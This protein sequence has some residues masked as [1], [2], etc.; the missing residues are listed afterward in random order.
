MDTIQLTIDGYLD[1]EP[2]PGPRDTA[3][4]RLILSPTDDTAQETVLHCITG[5]PRIV[6]M[7]LTE[8]RS[9]D[10]LRITGL[11]TLPA[12][13]TGAVQLYVDELEVL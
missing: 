9:G 10:L 5:D 12:R 13:A 1:T 7:L 6:H 8:L 11:L 4:F 3:R 2:V